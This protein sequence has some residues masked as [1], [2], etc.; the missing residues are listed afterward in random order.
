M[1]YVDM[2]R[3][4]IQ[5]NATQLITDSITD[6]SFLGCPS[7]HSPQVSHWREVTQLQPVKL[8]FII[9]CTSKDTREDP[10]GSLYLRN[11]IKQPVQIHFI[12]LRTGHTW[13]HKW[14]TWISD[15][16]SHLVTPVLKNSKLDI[17]GVDILIINKLWNTQAEWSHDY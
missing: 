6:G 16:L 9:F 11:P 14:K 13:R 15:S 1:I 17:S 3:T 10:N 5:Y 8:C 2:Q 4:D 7:S 12:H